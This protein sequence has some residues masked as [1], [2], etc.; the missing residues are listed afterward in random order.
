MSGEVYFEEN[1][2]EEG[3]GSVWEREKCGKVVK[4]NRRGGRC[5]WEG[6]K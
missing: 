1:D 5:V 2:E 4:G 6:Q 3:K